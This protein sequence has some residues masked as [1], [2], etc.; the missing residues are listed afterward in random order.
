V[1]SFAISRGW[2]LR[3]L[4]V[5]NSFLHGGLE[6][7]VY[8]CQPPS[9][10][11]K[12]MPNYVCKLDKTLYGLKQ[13]PRAWYSKLSTKLC[14]LGFHAS[15]ADTS[16]FYFY[17]NDITMFVLVYVDDIITASSSQKATKQ[18]LHKLSQEFK[19][20]DLGDLHYFLGIEV[21]KVSNGIV[22]TQE[23]YA[24]DLL[25]RVGMGDCK[26]VVSPMSTSEKLS[27]FE[28][29]PLGQHDSTQCRSI[30][31]ALQYLTLTS[32]DISFAVNKVCQ[33]LHAPTTIHWAVVKRIF[34]YLKGSTQ[35]GLMIARCKSLLITGFSDADWDGSLDDHRSIGGYAIF[36]GTNLVLW[37]ARKQNTVSRSSAEAEYKAVANAMAKIVWIQTLMKEIKVPCPT[38]AK[39]WCD[40]I[41]ANYLSANPAFMQEPNTL[42]LISTLLEKEYRKDC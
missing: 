5:Q 22:L 25:Q 29:S 35:I 33:F 1:F 7:D 41:S 32:P 36:V 28:G 42:K 13:A 9:Y 18:L 10:E 12:G 37:S 8:M 2:N 24:L 39:L 21:H 40:N 15:K 17:H 30:V 6:E 14:D 26:P 34:R 20:K 3:Q 31:G 27:V 4:D 16:L 23:K 38:M 11:N 19:L